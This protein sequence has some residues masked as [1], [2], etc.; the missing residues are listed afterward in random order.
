[1]LLVFFL[2]GYE[3]WVM[4]VRAY[5]SKKLRSFLLHYGSPAAV[6]V[7]CAGPNDIAGGL[8]ASVGTCKGLVQPAPAEVEVVQQE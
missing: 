3:T 8:C 7:S 6:V 4:C 1:M 5:L 2:L